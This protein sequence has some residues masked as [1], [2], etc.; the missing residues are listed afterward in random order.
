MI[1]AVE[2]PACSDSRGALLISPF[3]TE[4]RSRN[5][6]QW[7]QRYRRKTDRG[8]TEFSFYEA[9]SAVSAMCNK[10]LPKVA[11]RE[12]KLELASRHIAVHMEA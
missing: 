2:P 1:T 3:T 12:A 8:I 10:H 9:M 5:S 11:F 6:D 7:M 4:L